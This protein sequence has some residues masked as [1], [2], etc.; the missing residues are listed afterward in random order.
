VSALTA[1]VGPYW[2]L[3]LLGQ[4]TFAAV[5]CGLLVYVVWWKVDDRRNRLARQAARDAQHEREAAERAEML[6]FLKAWAK[7]GYDHSADAHRLMEKAAEVMRGTPSV[8]R[9]VAAVATVVPPRTADAV[10]EKMNTQHAAGDSGVL[11]RPEG[12][13]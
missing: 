2:L 10:V 13:P 8:E 1:A 6:G 12:R 5:N 11:G 3:L 9:I 7:S 4:L